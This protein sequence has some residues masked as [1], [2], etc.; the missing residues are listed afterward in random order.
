MGEKERT[1]HSD[2]SFLSS[3][4]SS[5]A[6]EIHSLG[7]NPEPKEEGYCLFSPWSWPERKVV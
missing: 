7:G 3:F 5:L 1:K 2:M 4:F 6:A